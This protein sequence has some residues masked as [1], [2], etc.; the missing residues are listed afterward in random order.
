ML[1]ESSQK[2]LKTLVAKSADLTNKPFQHSVINVKGEIDFYADELD[3]T[4]NILCRDIDGRR[5]K[6]NDLEIELFRSNKYIVL[7]IAKLNFP[8]SAI[9]ASAH[10]IITDEALSPNSL[11]DEV[12]IFIFNYL[13]YTYIG[14]FLCQNITN[15]S[16]KSDTEE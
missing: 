6:V 9:L 5:V 16:T 10:S 11:D 1:F 2:D 3:I 14:S 7:V 4:L 15:D 12:L 13:S 8:D